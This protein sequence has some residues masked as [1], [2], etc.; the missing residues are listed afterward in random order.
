MSAS[1]TDLQSQVMDLQKTLTVVNQTL[2][3]LQ[4]EI[5]SLTEADEFDVFV[6]NEITPFFGES[7]AENIIKMLQKCRKENH[8]YQFFI[9]VYQWKNIHGDL[10]KRQLLKLVSAVYRLKYQKRNGNSNLYSLRSDIKYAKACPECGKIADSFYTRLQK[11]G[12][13]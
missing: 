1:I 2:N 6:Q 13:I 4:G 9:P 11:E 10:Q 7:T 5:K 12:L 8:N 3:H